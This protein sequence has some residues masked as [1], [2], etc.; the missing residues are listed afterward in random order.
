MNVPYDLPTGAFG[1]EHYK[2][3]GGGE[4]P[5]LLFKPQEWR[6]EHCADGKGSPPFGK[7][8]CPTAEE[9]AARLGGY[10]GGTVS[11]VYCTSDGGWNLATLYK[12]VALLGEHVEVVDHN[13]LAAMADA[14]DGRSS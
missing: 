1:A 14:R 13:Q 8:S 7:Y 4:T 12:L 5:A 10:A 9:L 6:G 11:A 2:A 3:L